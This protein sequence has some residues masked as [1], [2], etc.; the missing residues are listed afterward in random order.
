VRTPISLCVLAALFLS[1]EAPAQSVSERPVAAASAAGAEIRVDGALDEAAWASASPITGFVQRDP[2]EGAEPTFRTEA[3]VLYDAAAVYVGVRAY[4][5]NPDRI[6]GY[7]TRRDASSSSEWIHVF[8]DSYHDRRTA[9]QFGVNPAGVKQD[10]YWFNDDNNDQ[11]WDAVWDVAAVRDA[12]G[13]RAEFRIPYSQLRFSRG[14][15]GRLGFAVIRNVSRLDETVSWP[16]VARSGTG[17]VSQFGELTGIATP[18]TTK[19]L[20]LVPYTVAQV[21]TA[22]EQPGNPLHNSV[23]TGASIGVD[24]KYAITPALSLNATVNP[25]FGQVEADPAV[26]NLGAFETFFNERR[27]FFIEGSGTYQF[28]CFDC[29]IFYSRRIGRQPRGFP[30]LA[31]DEYA[32]QPSQSTILGAAKLTGRVGS[33]SVGVLTAVTQE[34]TARIASPLGRRDHIVEPGTLYSVSRARREFTDQSSLGFI[35]TTANRR[36]V[37]SVSF[38]PGS[39]ITG[40]I[41]YDWRLGRWF[42]LNGY[43]AGS[44][45]RGTTEAIGLLQQ[46]NV[47]S[48]QRPDAG[49]VEFDPTADALNGHSGQASFGKI[50]GERTRFNVTASYRSPGFDVNDVGFLPRADAVSQNAWFQ[51]RRPNPGRILRDLNVNFNQYSDRNFDGDLINLGGNVNGQAS[52]TN[53]WSAGGGARINAGTLNDRLTRGGPAG[54]IDRNWGGWQWFNTNDRKPVSFHWDSSVGWNIDGSSGYDVNPRIQVRPGSAVS[55][56]IGVAFSK[57]HDTAQWVANFDDGGR[58]RYVFG[59]LQQR[60]S[61]MTFRVNYTLTPNLSVQLYG[62]PFVSAGRYERYTEMVDGRAPFESRFVPF[63]YPENA[64]FKVLSFRTTNVMRWEFKPGSTLFVVWQQGREGFSPDGSFKFGRDYGEVF[65]TPSTNTVL[66]KLAYW[67]NP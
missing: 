43:W 37:D 28:Q 14:S 11:S 42:G 58:T 63:A 4:D 45:V 2:R 21:F 12:T 61:S 6:V 36:L 56:E 8:I 17:F 59:E 35:L 38:L 53:L 7:L 16:L 27:P 33:F 24:L 52:F 19:R 10:S 55:A 62:Q 22:P 47:H 65:S 25:D 5:D 44:S 54:I 18:G 1:A 29:S 30:A 40:G 20:E 34:E 66:V 67:F 13:W 26:V 32:A 39:A 9:Y 31:D 48:F 51:I 41:D 60:T 15:D 23:D 64:D 49:H 50:S 57:N 46:S 3:R